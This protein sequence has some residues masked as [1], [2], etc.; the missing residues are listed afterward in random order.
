MQAPAQ[1]TTS[2]RVGAVAAW[3]VHDVYGNAALIQGGRHG[4][5]EV[6]TGDNIP[7]LGRVQSIHQ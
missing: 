7:G 6:T 1:P 4:P 3:S 5:I 2:Q